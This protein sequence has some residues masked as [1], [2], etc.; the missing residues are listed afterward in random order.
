MKISLKGFYRQLIRVED[1]GDFENVLTSW[2]KEF[3]VRNNKKSFE[4]I[5]RLMENQKEDVNWFSSLVGFFYEHG[6]GVVVDKNKS[7]ELYLFTINNDDGKNKKLVSVY[8]IINIIIAKYLLSF[9]YYKDILLDKRNSFTKNYLE[10]MH[11]MLNSQFENFN[12]LEIDVCK[13]EI[14]SIE[15]YLKSGSK[16]NQVKK[17]KELINLNN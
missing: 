2:V 13:D 16:G 5:L 7:L 6:L 3:F 17:E 15:K 1:Y 4:K 12:G 10:S 9:S 11:I 8:Q 14:N